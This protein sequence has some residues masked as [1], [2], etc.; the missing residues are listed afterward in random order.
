VTEA[1]ESGKRA[2]SPGSTGPTAGPS[3]EGPQLAESNDFVFEL[4]GCQRSGQ[5]VECHLRIANRG[6]D[7]SLHL[8]QGS[9]IFD[10][11]GNQYG[12]FRGEI[13]NATGGLPY[14]SSRLG[15][16]LIHNVPVHASL[17]FAGFSPEASRITSFYLVGADDDNRF[18]VD[19]R[20]IPITARPIAGL[21]GGAEGGPGSTGTGGIKQILKEEAIDGTKKT[22]KKWKDKFL[23]PEE[24]A[25]DD[26]GQRR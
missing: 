3:Q 18:R 16:T 12:P 5:T 24:E 25:S 23:G 14:S 6:S 7:R 13:A 26:D 20:N 9:R 10:E 22:I 2:S 1:G 8:Y 4:Q 11:R 15:Q 17:S 19:F 21:G